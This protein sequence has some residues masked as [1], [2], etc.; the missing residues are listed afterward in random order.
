MTRSTE[1]SAFPP[2][3]AVAIVLFLL[4]VVAP[5]GWGVAQESRLQ[6]LEVPL[7]FPLPPERA[8]LIQAGG[9]RFDRLANQ[10][11][12]LWEGMWDAG[13]GRIDRLA[14]Q[15]FRVALPSDN[16][17]AIDA[18]LRDLLAAHPDL[19]AAEPENLKT[20]RL[21]LH[22]GIWWVTYG[23]SLDGLPV[24]GARLDLR[25]NG[26]G[27]L[28]L[29]R[30]RTIRGL[31]P[32]PGGMTA[33]EAEAR[34]ALDM[35]GEGLVV[36]GIA[37]P[38]RGIE[39]CGPTA[40]VIVPVWNETAAAFEARRA[41]RV[42]LD[43]L[44]PVRARFR[45]Y[46]DA[47][48]GAILGRTNEIVYALAEGTVRGDQ[49]PS[50]PTDPS[51]RSLFEDLRVAVAG[52][53]TAYTDE[54]GHFDIVFPDGVARAATARLEG[55]FC[56]VNRQDGA[57]AELTGAAQPGVPLGFVFQ[58]GNS[59]AAERDVFFHTNVAHD[60]I[61][62]IDPA[63]T[64]LDYE[65]PAAVN[66]ALSCNAYW[67]GTG[68]NFYQAGGGC[69][70]TGQ[71]A[72]VIYHEYGH[73][74]S[75]F[76]YA[77][78][79][80]SSAMGE[81][82]SD[83][84]AATITDQSKIGLGFT[85]PG[86]WLRDCD[87]TRTW[88][89]P[90]CGGEPHCVG[91]VVAGA[92]WDMR[93]NLVAAVGDHDAGVALA[94]HLFHFGRF[95]GNN[96]FEGYYFDLLAVDDDNGT[97]VDGTPH[98]LSII[99]A[100]DRH[101]IGPG[102]VL[103][104]LHT[105]PHD[106]DRTL[107]PVP[108]IAVFSSA[109]PLLADSLAVYYSTQPIAGGPVTGPTRLQMVPTGGIREYRTEIPG[110]PLGTRVRYFL[111]G[112]T[113]Q[114]GL[115]AI[116]PSGAPAEQ[117][118]FLVAQ[119]VTPP[120]IVH[121]A[122]TERSRHVWPVPVEATV[123]DN[124]AIGSVTLE[125]RI[126]GVA[127]LPVNLSA[128]GNNLYRGSFV[129]SVA[130]GDVV[131]YRIRATDAAASPNVSFFPA[132][133]Y[134]QIPIVRDMVNEMEDGTQDVT[135]REGTIG[136]VDQWHL[137]TARNHTP[138]GGWSWKCGD[139][140]AGVYADGADG[141][142]EILPVV[143]GTGASLRFWDWMA[144]EEGGPG[145][146]WD[147]G[148]VEVS[149]DSGVSWNPLAPIGG[150]THAIIDN[151]ASP[152]PPGYPVWSG[153]HDWQLEEFDLS[154]YVG[155]VVRLRWRFGSD[156]YMTYEGWHLDDLTLVPTTNEAAGVDLQEEGAPLRSAL[157]GITPNP[158]RSGSSIRFAVAGR[159]GPVLVTIHDVGGRRVRTLAEGISEPGRY[160]RFW[161]GRDDRGRDVASGVYF[162]RIGWKGGDAARR[163]LLLR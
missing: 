142:L 29:I 55:R 36:E 133:G 97:L 54:V 33:P 116:D 145:Q 63:F 9:E 57:D 32:P 131:E 76:A 17:E 134:V 101:A 34:A 26:Q 123:T 158:S 20:I 40:E 157:L 64:D 52:I 51:T 144:A 161:D 13:A 106:T 92:L 130:V 11:G 3:R 45:S 103:E 132:S 105:P 89:A 43:V 5:I 100:F 126:G 135:H 155:Q 2:M 82:F 16:A 41:F 148:L 66:I 147:G 125:V 78:A 28:L 79:S 102:F 118:E 46:V 137:S 21:A 150:Y 117:H 143:L 27:D 128:Q 152:F 6:D 156:G 30:D 53:G 60:A 8:A 70:N 99:E 138:G 77:P 151:P 19:L 96:D 68:I 141:V 83:Y 15:R 18:R 146:A 163:L 4:A 31:L 44:T 49:Q 24:V 42:R 47:R 62:A 14:P 127:R 69:A 50:T 90:E 119:D 84:F 136:L 112:T 65:M 73:G 153:S 86:T 71:I 10:T 159:T 25:L 95:G 88:P 115:T 154:A 162:V 114:M 122:K 110:Q 1:L 37:L 81:G 67:D 38:L 85:G 109:V 94:D 59:V 74:I 56:N 129:G 91:E 160:E 22:G 35:E 98:A 120:T 121:E 58:D 104:I 12:T 140:G 124:Q 107:T 80:P 75:Q 61:V 113:S 149:T 108:L 87:N 111:T 7:P 39:E 72:D 23:Q 139:T 48:D 93:A